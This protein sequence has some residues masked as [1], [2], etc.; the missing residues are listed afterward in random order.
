MIQMLSK[1]AS[2]SS[3]RAS[4]S[5][6]RSSSSSRSSS[7][8]SKSSSS[9]KSSKSTAPKTSAKAGTSKAKPGSTVKTADGKT[10]KSSA[11]KPT[12]TRYSQS[13]G[14][15]GDNGY[16][17]RFTNGYS[18]PAGSV[19]YY[20]D[21]SFTDY[22][23]LWYIIGHNSPRNDQATIMQPDNKQLVAKPE[24]SGLDGLLILNWIFMILIIAAT[25]AGIV[26]LVNKFTKKGGSDEYS[27]QAA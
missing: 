15:V 10:I 12:N 5:G 7:A 4:S 9:S 8:S 20:P 21:H 27:R 24:R 6:A 22:L 1:G 11:T 26:Y 13:K 18:A 14:I 3:G 2:V 25:G 19:V 16:T 23:L 17:P